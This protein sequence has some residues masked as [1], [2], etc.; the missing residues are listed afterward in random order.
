M[1]GFLPTSL[2][3]ASSRACAEHELHFLRGDRL[4][5]SQ[6]SQPHHVVCVG[7]QRRECEFRC[8]HSLSSCWGNPA[9]LRLCRLLIAHAHVRVLLPRPRD[10]GARASVDDEISEFTARGHVS[11][12]HNGEQ[13]LCIPTDFTGHIGQACYCDQPTS[14]GSPA[15]NIHIVTSC[16][17]GQT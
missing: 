3:F 16:P 4:A 14:T 17:S 6:R 12:A 15:P 2:C 9:P 11:T 13:G 1:Q 8:R 7:G 5:I 10:G